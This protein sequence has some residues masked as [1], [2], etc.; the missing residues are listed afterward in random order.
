MRRMMINKSVMLS[1]FVVFVL[2]CGCSVHE[3]PEIP[4]FKKYHLRLNY[5]TNM[6]E[7]RHYFDKDSIIHQG[8]GK[9]YDNHLDYGQIRYVVRTYPKSEIARSRSN[10]TQEFV[11][12]KSISAGYNH[13]VTIDLLR[14]DYDIMVW[15]DL[16]QTDADKNYYN[17]INF[18]EIKLHGE[19][20]GNL[21]YRDAFRGVNSITATV[22]IM[23]TSIDT[24]DIAMQRP[25]AKF[26]FITNDVTEFIN[27]EI[28]RV[29]AKSHETPTRTVNV[30]DYKIVFYYVGFMPNAYC[31]HTDKPIDSYT[32]ALFESTLK[33]LNDT[34]AS[35]GFDYV[36]VNGKESGATIQIGLYDKEGN[37]LS[38]TKPMGVPLKRNHHTII[39]GK[40]LTAET[41][42]GISINPDFSGDHNLI[43]P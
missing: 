5:E 8:F 14:G 16:I 43:F 2:L 23:T 39:T 24:I 18:D 6:T 11:F 42:G 4:E 36:F 25:L 27:K 1:T 17:A 9:T 3:F 37:Q 32:G 12:T 19:H 30:D 38:L 34:E 10:Y 40:F 20:K 26:E 31:M 35:L 15:S 28:A 33:K 13:E 22:D 29:N 21:D 7:W 41:A